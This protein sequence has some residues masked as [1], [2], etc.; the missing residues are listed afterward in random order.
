MNKDLRQFLQVVKE[1]GPDYYV[2]IIKPLKPNLEVCVIQQKLAKEERFPV[3]YCPEIVGSKLPLVTNLFGSYEMLGLAL[4]MEPKKVDK[5]NIVNEFRRM[6]K[7]PKPTQMV[8]GPEAPIKDIIIQGKDVDLS[9]LPIIHHAEL[10]S[11]KYVDI[12]FTICKDPDTGIPNA[13]VYRHEVKGRSDLGCGIGPYQHGA[14]IARR[15][16][17]LNKPMEVV[18]ALGHHPAVILGSLTE[19]SLDVNELEI[20]GGFLG[21]PLQVTQAETVDLP[22]PTHAEIAIEGVIDARNMT[23]DAPFAEYTGYYGTPAPCYIIKV[24]AI[25]MRQDAIYHDLDP[26]H[27]EHNLAGVLCFESGVY[28][29][30]RSAVPSVKA[31]HFPPS[32][33]CVT[34]IYVS[35]KKRVQGEGKLAGMAALSAEPE[36]K[37]V[38]VVDEDV[39]VYDEQEVLWAIASRVQA[40]T[41]VSV[42]PGALGPMLDPSNYDETR[43]KR[44]HMVTK[45]IVDATKPVDLPFA[46]RTTPPKEL[47]DSMNLKDYL[48]Q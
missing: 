28:D 11:G 36:A 5:A 31:V 34:H 19:E 12:G 40:D 23:T 39:D 15:H 43:L 16:A 42:I 14:Y 45:V 4:G 35:I 8:P 1:A 38:V 6:Q 30:V 47:W 29:A 17:E 18:I 37:M 25:T 7:D 33:G 22:V 21:E 10:D 2:E 32:G 46:T 44:G 41:D 24:T 9:F 13:G 26:A 27:R 20:M 3:I 48:K